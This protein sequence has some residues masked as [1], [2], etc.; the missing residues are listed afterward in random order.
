M[1]YFQF[2]RYFVIAPSPNILGTTCRKD[3]R[4]KPF[5][6]QNNEN[7]KKSEAFSYI[8]NKKCTGILRKNLEYD[9]CEIEEQN[10]ID[11]KECDIKQNSRL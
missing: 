11:S 3:K 2:L 8:L 5:A 10:Q 7:R 9:P 1:T 4:F 6:N